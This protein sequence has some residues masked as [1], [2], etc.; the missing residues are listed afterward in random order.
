MRVCQIHQY[1]PYWNMLPIRVM[2]RVLLYPRKAVRMPRSIT[3]L[4][5]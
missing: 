2:R 3:T 4:S 1:T 5:A